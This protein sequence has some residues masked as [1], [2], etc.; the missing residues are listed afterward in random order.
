MKRRTFLIALG[1]GL[2]LAWWLKPGDRGAPH[3][4]YFQALNDLF[5][6]HGP[7]RPVLLI[8]RQRLA[9]NCQRLTALLPPGRDYRIVAK[10]LPSV[11]LI[12][13]V[14]AQTGTRRV[15]VFHQPFI[16]ALATAEPGCDLLLGKPM[17]VNAAERFY[18]E[19]PAQAAF[20]PDQQLQWLIDSEA[21]LREY[22]ALAEKRQRR[23]LINI[24]LDV[25]LHR[26]GLATP[27]QLDPLLAL[28][29]AHPER[30]GFSGFMGYD[31]HVGKLPA[32][33]ESRQDSL[34]KSQAVYQSFI[35]RLYQ[36]QPK[37]R[38]QRLT[39]NGAGSP[40]VA[41][42]GDETP[43][44]E[45][46]V[47]SALVKP[48]DFDLDTLAEFEPAAFIAAPVLKAMDGLQLPGPLPLGDAWA[49]W[50]PNRARTYFIY[51][52]YWKAQPVS[53]P[54]IEA[55]GL[56]G[57]STNQMMYNGADSTALEVNDQIFFRPTQSEF[58]LLQF[59]DLAAV[60]DGSLQDW[61]PPLPQGEGA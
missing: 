3:P 1:G 12:R 31:A 30:L 38:E 50:D 29:E 10:S 34:R 49:L 32:V 15:M 40:T 20:D 2:A 26:G 53:P 56:Y 14:M 7:G 44:N 36:L 27:E 42:H 59:G 22:L 47:G 52:G 28:I 41:L 33:V 18:E 37:Y 11:P 4:P 19:L 8:D 57:A 61:W 9:A 17:P 60:S 46:A 35:D 5:R 55:N 21:R 23:L 45:L 39:F 58:V 16:T 43:L 24:E 51:G 54:G 13:E 25:G 48:T 6:Q